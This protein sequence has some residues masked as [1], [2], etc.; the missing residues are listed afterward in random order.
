MAARRVPP[1][2]RLHPS[3]ADPGETERLLRRLDRLDPSMQ[4]L[5][6][7]MRVVNMLRH[8]NDAFGAMAGSRPLPPAPPRRGDRFRRGTTKLLAL[9][10]PVPWPK[11]IRTLTALDQRA[12]GSAPGVVAAELAELRTYLDRCAAGDVPAG[13]EHPSLG[14]LSTWEWQRWAYL[15]VDHHLRQFGV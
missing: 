12:G 14:P 9:Y 2:V 11:G 15:H 5:W 7:R 10:L 3:L 4:P 8:L 1:R 6:G 13:R